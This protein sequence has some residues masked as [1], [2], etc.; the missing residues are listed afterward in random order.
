MKQLSI[1]DTSHRNERDKNERLK[2]R[3]DR[4]EKYMKQKFKI[5]QWK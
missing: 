2:L 5:D 3:F 1:R 4:W